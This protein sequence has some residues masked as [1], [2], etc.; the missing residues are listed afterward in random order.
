MV[1]ARVHMC[2]DSL[3]TTY[4]YVPSLELIIK[5]IINVWI[6]APHGLAL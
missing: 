1:Y 3:P 4:V 2:E 6:Q 5:V